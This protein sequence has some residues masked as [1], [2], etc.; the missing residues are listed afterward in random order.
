M[1]DLEYQHHQ[2]TVLD[3]TDHPVVTHVV[4]PESREVGSQALAT[5]PGVLLSSGSGGSGNEA[6]SGQLSDRA[7]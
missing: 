5:V 3:V 2:F 7:S 1:G 6:G 4:A